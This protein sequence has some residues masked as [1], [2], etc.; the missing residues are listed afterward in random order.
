MSVCAAN[1]A[2]KTPPSRDWAS[3]G[4]PVLA[5]HR[6]SRPAPDRAARPAAGS[7]P[8]SSAG[9]RSPPAAAPAPQPRESQARPHHMQHAAS[10]DKS[11][12][13]LSSSE[14]VANLPA[15]RIV[16][17]P[18]RSAFQFDCSFDPG[19]NGCMED[20]RGRRNLPS[21][22]SGVEETLPASLNHLVGPPGG[23][24]EL[25]HDL[26]WSGRRSFDLANPVQRYMYHM[27][28]LTSGATR[29]HYTNWLN[30]DLLRSEWTS[31]GLPPPLRRVWE[32]HFPE[33]ASAGA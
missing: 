32:G 15:T 7:A 13:M 20:A 19:Q 23:V 9:A 6:R 22:W 5:A 10:S 25:P 8:A 21:R 31:L 27:T 28:V 29:E 14:S 2:R 33:L 30:M 26:A 16:P 1:S 17:W 24:V 12:Q 11:D 3:P 4:G 18:R